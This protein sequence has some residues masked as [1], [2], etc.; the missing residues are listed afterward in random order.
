MSRPLL[1]SLAFALVLASAVPALAQTPTPSPAPPAVDPTDVA[2]PEAAIAAVYQTI[3]GPAGTPRN[4]DRLRGVMAP[5]ARFTALH[6]VDGVVKVRS[7]TVEEY[8]ANAGP[9]FAKQGFYERGVL[10][11]VNR[12][13]HIETAASPYES[14]HAPGEAPFARGINQFR[15]YFDGKRWWVESI[16]WEDETTALALPA[17]ANA[18]LKAR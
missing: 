17:D 3:S 2:S 4:W 5:N 9:Y 6:V 11:H 8:I 10:T 15:L 12:W 14:R 16:M 1:R 7:L 13:G 18:A